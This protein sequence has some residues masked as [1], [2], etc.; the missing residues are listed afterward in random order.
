MK[1]FRKRTPEAA[2]K[3]VGEL[4]LAIEKNRQFFTFY[5]VFERWPD[6]DLTGG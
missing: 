4:P 2:G 3:A 5:G 6:G 1:R